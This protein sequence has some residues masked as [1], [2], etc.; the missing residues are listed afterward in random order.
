M[1]MR[2]YLWLK[3]ITISTAKHKLQ[4]LVVTS[5][6]SP[7]HSKKSDE[8]VIVTSTLEWHLAVI[9]H[10]QPSGPLSNIKY[11]TAFSI[12]YTLDQKM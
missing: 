3:V 8:F 12:T 1:V 7:K 5:M 10:L 2:K 4:L 11:Y 9:T 6:C